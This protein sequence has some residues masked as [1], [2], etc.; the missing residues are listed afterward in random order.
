MVNSMWAYLVFAR[1]SFS[2]LT[3]S[4]GAIWPPSSSCCGC[5]LASEEEGDG[6]AAVDVLVSDDGAESAAVWE[7]AEPHAVRATASA[8]AVAAPRTPV[9]AERTCSMKGLPQEAS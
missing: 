9:R 8:A 2:F 6:S 4:A 3:K 7:S 1:P 5:S